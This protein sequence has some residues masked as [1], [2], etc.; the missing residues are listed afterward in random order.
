MSQPVRVKKSR[1]LEGARP[2]PETTKVPKQQSAEDAAHALAKAARQ[3][4]REAQQT[5]V[6]RV[7]SLEEELYES[8]KAM[9]NIATLQLYLKL[10]PTPA[11]GDSS[12]SIDG[13]DDTYSAPVVIAASQ[14][15]RRVFIANLKQRTFALN[16][17]LE[18]ARAAASAA[19]AGTA[20]AAAAAAAQ[21]AQ[22]KIQSWLAVQCQKY[23]QT[24]VSLIA[25]S[26]RD[27]VPEGVVVACIDSL[28]DLAVAGAGDAQAKLSS[29]DTINPFSHVRSLS[30]C[31]AAFL[32]TLLDPLLI[33]LPSSPP[34]AAAP[35]ADHGLHPRALPPDAPP[36]L[37]AGQV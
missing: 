12:V 2:Y 3:R 16:S 36:R 1:R 11:P 4:A 24:L 33:F 34:P 35:G 30:S 28:V 21:S 17:S 5:A 14:A 7:R 8:K 37:L 25:F 15:L 13:E 27:S 9:N 32:F 29:I 23:A 19:A 20:S 22:R 6:A 26:E 10:K 18:N 31:T